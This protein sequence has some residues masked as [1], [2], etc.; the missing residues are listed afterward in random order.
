MP[1]R[2]LVRA[3]LAP[4]PRARPGALAA[5]R[6][7]AAQG[8]VGRGWAAAPAVS[9]QVLEAQAPLILAGSGRRLACEGSVALAAVAVAAPDRMR[10]M[11]SKT[12]RRYSDA[13]TR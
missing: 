10:P 5:W 1:T 2:C 7:E 13:P 4:A 3:A 8:W 9:P 6:Q 12:L 11:L